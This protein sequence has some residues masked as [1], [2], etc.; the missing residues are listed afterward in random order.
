MVRRR[1]LGWLVLVADPFSPLPLENE[2]LFPVDGSRDA[3]Q[4]RSAGAGSGRLRSEHL[5]LSVLHERER[6]H[7]EGEAEQV[8]PLAAVPDGVGPAEEQGVVEA[9]VDGL[10]VVALAEQPVEVRI[11]GR[12]RPDV[13]GPVEPPAFVVVVAVEPDGDGAAVGEAVVNRPGFVGGS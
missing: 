13:L 4:P 3:R 9:T 6:V 11:L 2:R 1:F 8:D 7:H 12:D 5:G 10:G